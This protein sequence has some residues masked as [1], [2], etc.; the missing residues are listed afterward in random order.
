MTGLSIAAGVLLVVCVLSLAVGAK[1]IAAGTVMQ[2][3]TDFDGSPDHLV[4]RELRLPRTLIGL[5]VGAALGAAG[6]LMQAMTRNPLADPGL[7]GVSAGASLAVVL[8]I[9]LF[10][11]S[12]VLALVWFALAG[13]A[14]AS[15]AVYALGSVGR[16]GAASVRLALAGVAMAALL[17]ALTW[18]VLLLDQ[19]A[20]DQFRFWNVGS[21]AGRDTTV[22]AQI[23]PF[24]VAG[25][26]VG[27]ACARSLNAIGLGDDAARALGIRV[28]WTRAATALAVTLLCGAA[29][30]A[31]GPIGFV[32][33]VVPL[34]A[35]V[36]TGPDQRW[37]LPYAA[38]VGAVVLLGCDIVGRVIDRPS[39]VQ[40][41]IVTA[42][43]GGPVFVML[44]RRVKMAQL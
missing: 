32:G 31:C 17:T 21:L 43:I 25:L 40:V 33:L 11:F 2:A 44:V 27:L 3:V 26:A 9:W 35:R 12:S 18:A 29:T 13:S 1:P 36:V 10:G 20:L 8:A 16:S 15:A 37:L 6:A 30:A 22:L 41:G 39:E 38:V 5:L 24:I 4:V 28:G 23:A 7:L 42:G 19:A 34:A 14:L